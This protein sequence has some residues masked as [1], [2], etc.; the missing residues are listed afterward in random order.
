MSNNTVIT[1][2]AAQALADDFKAFAADKDAIASTGENVGNKL[3][4]RM[5][6]AEKMDGQFGIGRALRDIAKKLDMTFTAECGDGDGVSCTRQAGEDMTEAEKKTVA[7]F[8]SYGSIV[9]NAVKYNVSPLGCDTFTELRK[10]VE[11][12]KGPS[13]YKEVSDHWKAVFDTIKGNWPVLDRA[14]KD[15]V[16]AAMTEAAKQS[17]IKV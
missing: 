16:L 13:A 17:F 11:Q 3:L 10:A 1:D 14:G 15:T 2:A 7:T 6:A 4:H 12:A 8:R 5:Q 9:N